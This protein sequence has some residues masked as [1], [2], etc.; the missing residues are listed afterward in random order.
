MKLKI[1]QS[2]Q[3]VFSRM[4]NK[5]GSISMFVLIMMLVLLP[6]TIWV[7]VH[8]PQKVQA[9]YSVKQMAI[10]TANSII[11]RLDETALSEG[12]VRVDVAEGVE[13]AE[14]MVK[15]T[16]NLDENYNPS[17]E[18]LLQ[19]RVPIWY[20]FSLDDLKTVENADSGDVYY[21]LPNETGVYVFFINE[22]TEKLTVLTENGPVELENTSVIVRAN[23]PIETGGLASRTM[24]TKTGI[25]EAT[26]NDTGG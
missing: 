4:K 21:K 9:T 26:L 10:N 24:I 20:A 12:H 5:Q 11:T 18:G 1:K 3:H 17:G 25:A 7:G 14:L 8:L 6:W 19:E 13:I 15:G 23:I 22:P 2:I 16:L